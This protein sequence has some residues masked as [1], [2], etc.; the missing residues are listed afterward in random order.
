M[1]GI[2]PTVDD[3]FAKL[4]NSAAVL[5]TF[6]IN[7]QV[8][9]DAATEGKRIRVDY[10]N[11]LAEL[12][13]RKQASPSGTGFSISRKPA[14]DY[15]LRVSANYDIWQP[16]MDTSL[17]ARETLDAVLERFRSDFVRTINDNSITLRVAKL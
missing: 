2:A 15:V 16:D 10:D 9:L 5:R 8:L 7:E 12:L 17:G 1:F 3:P 13:A 11:A 14:S 4:E 6:G